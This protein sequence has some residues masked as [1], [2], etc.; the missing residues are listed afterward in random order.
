[1][2]GYI[3][4]PAETDRTLDIVRYSKRCIFELWEGKAVFAGD[5]Y[6]VSDNFARKTV[7]F[8]A[9]K[10]DCIFMKIK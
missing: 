5:T 6:G 10:E 3:A 1:M 2:I 9:G 7:A 8:Q 4:I